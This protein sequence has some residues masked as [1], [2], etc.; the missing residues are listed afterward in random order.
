M[1]KKNKK[2]LNPHQ[3]QPKNFDPI[4]QVGLQRHGPLGSGQTPEF[5]SG[6]FITKSLVFWTSFC[7]V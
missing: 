3:N 1:V 6:F 2:T 4:D 7:R 5:G